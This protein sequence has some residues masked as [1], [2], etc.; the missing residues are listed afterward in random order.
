MLRTYLTLLLLVT[1]TPLIA[2]QA[3]PS[4]PPQTARQALIEMFTGKSPDAFEKHLPE[5]ARHALIHK[6]DSGQTSFVQQFAAASRELSSRGKQIETY[7]AGPLLLSVEDRGGQGKL[8]ATVER[9]NLMGEEDEIEVSFQ[10]FQEGEAKPLPVVPRFIFTMKQEKEMWRVTE[11][12]L[13]IHA[14]LA[15]PEYLKT[16]TKMQNEENEAMA[17]GRI[18][19]LVQAETTYAGNHPQLGYT[20]KQ[21]DLNSKD[22]QNDAEQSSAAP[23][24][25]VVASDETSGFRFAI[26]GCNSMPAATFH[27]TAVP[28]ESDSG[29]KAFCA[30]S[31][32]KMRFATDGTAA[33][34]LTAGEVVPQEERV[35]R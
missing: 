20:C 12:E 14:P 2:A 4:P 5:A 3:Q 32:G 35:M 13:V 24:E 10:V 9:D 1:V 33:T 16:L 15:D 26:T 11:A 18:S 28:V 17:Q 34:C 8:E 6:G 27:I 29:M 23:S 30:D 25:P 22:D 19:E 31:S 21:S 7:D